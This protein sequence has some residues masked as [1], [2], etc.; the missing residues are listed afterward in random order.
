MKSLTASIPLSI[1]FL[2]AALASPRQTSVLVI[3]GSCLKR[4]ERT[5]KTRIEIP[6]NAHGDPDLAHATIFF[7]GVDYDPRCGR[8]EVRR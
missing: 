3:D 6:L 7:V 5:E 8:I 2:C 4:V 1:F